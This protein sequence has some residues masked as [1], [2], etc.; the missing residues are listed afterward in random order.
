MSNRLKITNTFNKGLNQDTPNY[1]TPQDLYTYL[2]N[3][4][5]ITH[6]GN[7]LILQNEKGTE[8]KTNLKENYI[9]LAIKAY[10]NVAY[11]ISAEAE[12]AETD[13]PVL[14]SSETKSYHKIQLTEEGRNRIIVTN[15]AEITIEFTYQLERNGVI[16]G[17]ILDA[18]TVGE[19]REFEDTGGTNVFAIINSEYNLKVDHFD[20][21]LQQS[22]IGLT[23]RGEVGTFPSPDYNNLQVLNNTSEGSDFRTVLVEEYNPL[24]NYAGDNDAPVG[25]EK[26]KTGYGEFNSA[27]FNFQ[28]DKEVEIVAI[29]PVYDGT[30]NIIFTDGFNKPKIVNSRFSVRS[31]NIVDIIERVGN[32]DTN[33]YTEDNFNNTLNHIFTSNKIPHFSFEG[34]DLSGGNLAAGSYKYYFKYITQDGEETSIIS[35]S[36]PVPVY[37]GERINEFRG[38][39][40]NENTTKT[41]KLRL[42]N[43]DTSYDKIK[44]YFSYRAGQ[45]GVTVV[46]AIFEIINTYNFT[47]TEITINHT[48]YET[49]LASSID[50]LNLPQQQIETYRT[51]C[52]I[53]GR[54]MVG[55]I[56]NKT[57]NTT[58]LRDFARNITVDY[59]VKEQEYVDI[60]PSVTLTEIN[61]LIL[62]DNTNASGTWNQG[63][64][65]PR[66]THDYLSYKPGES[67][68]FSASFIFDDSFESPLF[69]VRGIDNYLN[70]AV[71][72]AT[73]IEAGLSSDFLFR[74]G[75]GTSKGENIKGIYRFPD[76]EYLDQDA[77]TIFVNDKKVRTLLPKFNIPEIT[78]DLRSLGIIGI[79]FY[80][81]NRKKDQLDQGIVI[82]SFIV[83]DFE[84]SAQ[85]TEYGFLWQ[86]GSNSSFELNSLADVKLFP[87]LP[88][89]LTEACS[90]N[91]HNGAFDRGA[92]PKSQYIGVDPVILTTYK[93][94]RTDDGNQ[95]GSDR[96]PA[97]WYKKAFSFIGANTAINPLETQK[98]FSANDYYIK[99]VANINSQYSYRTKS[100][101]SDFYFSVLTQKEYTPTR[102]A[103]IDNVE[104][105][106]VQAQATGKTLNSFAS[107]VEFRAQVIDGASL[108]SP[109][110]PINPTCF[111]DDDNGDVDTLQIAYTRHFYK[112]N[113]YL[114]L[115]LEDPT[116]L[117]TPPYIGPANDL[118]P[119]KGRAGQ[120]FTSNVTQTET[121]L[122]GLH[123]VSI[124]Q[125]GG[126]RETSQLEGL[127]TP[128][129]EL[130]TPVSQKYYFNETIAN[131]LGHT[132][133]LIASGTVIGSGGDCYSMPVYRRIFQS[134]LDRGETAG[135][136]DAEDSNR[137]LRADIDVGYSIQFISDCDYNPI[138][139]EQTTGLATTDD[140][141]TFYPYRVDSFFP[142]DK[143][144]NDNP[145]RNNR[146]IETD[147]YN[148]GSSFLQSDVAAKPFD[149]NRP[150]IQNDFSTR[151]SF[152][153]I[154]NTNSFENAYRFFN[155]LAYK[156]YS[157]N[158]GEI[159]AL[160]SINGQL[161]CVQE[162]GI[163]LIPVNERIAQT[164]DSAGEV[165]FNDTQ[166]L[167]D[168]K[169]VRYLTENYG[170]TWQRSVIATD[171]TIYGIDIENAKIWRV[172]G[173]GVNLIS[174]FKV[175]SF[176]RD[177]QPL[178]KS[179]GFTIGKTQIRSYYD[180]FKNSVIF[181]FIKAEEIDNVEVTTPVVF[182]TATYS[183]GVIT[184]SGGYGGD[185][186]TKSVASY[187]NGVY[188]L[189]YN[190]QP[191]NQWK[192]YNTWYP[193]DM[194]NIR[195]KTYSFNIKENT[196]ELHQHY[197]SDRFSY[198]YNS[199]KDFVVE[200]NVTGGTQ[201][202]WIFENMQLVTNEVYPYKIEYTNDQGTF[203]QTLKPRNVE[204]IGA[205]G[206]KVDPEQPITNYNIVY[207]EGQM[208]LPV[209]RD[210]ADTGLLTNFSNEGVRDKYCKIRLYY[211]SD[212]KIYIQAV[213]TTISQSLS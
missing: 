208:Y 39:V 21:D 107:N 154:Y 194:F 156:D 143:K 169:H 183:D 132:N 196:N 61:N 87:I 185:L 29:Q 124:Y 1:Q 49:T 149:V 35:E 76:R 6:D 155:I 40:S 202:F 151:I 26:V 44:I 73:F 79:R 17:E 51:G 78:E 158:L 114:G 136:G 205:D 101:P 52:E 88:N 110:S 120:I 34:Q 117:F 54:L 55:N 59:E 96:T 150:F 93:Y 84:P 170:S 11:I 147:E 198:Y 10:G 91:G 141:R 38:G 142:T 41:N 81:S 181:S 82:P 105:D 99:K 161:I 19:S 60:D 22:F 174:D 77:G 165:F 172:E 37:F 138:F 116:E 14:L 12:Y 20:I 68:C 148:T 153:N 74:T 27:F 199:V 90:R 13:I 186:T 180:K 134:G 182:P 66:N 75:F 162:N 193:I 200:F 100:T 56:K 118:D 201:M 171:N 212:K 135:S 109:C 167:A 163:T 62:F 15:T 129:Y 122:N 53:K 121:L 89:G 85:H 57:F 63:F 188:T 126:P 131:E 71:Y 204:A 190:E 164:G 203:T 25:T 18:L 152:S 16:I 36:N 130:F 146:S 112:F 58:V 86:D 23:G 127:Y 8:V 97:Y 213:L 168:P 95:A 133:G 173:Q 195:D 139:R 177:I 102:S 119:T 166:V 9:P 31:N 176:L 157:R 92:I 2:E 197:I 175:Q 113:D 115:Y 72:S 140:I 207:K 50:S 70:N 47:G 94:G 209:V 108:Y 30:V 191:T 65:N 24:Y 210:D 184:I 45:G 137:I 67:Y 206:F 128:E 179:K 3:G 33:L 32:Q 125:N 159:V 69:P 104:V 178:F 98:L 211:N 192:C 189:V 80:R 123:L 28:E 106:Y 42:Q 103:V 160:R 83:P 187:N 7:E 64:Y 5:F 111:Y 144:N 4:T 48:G 43:L 46:P 145:F